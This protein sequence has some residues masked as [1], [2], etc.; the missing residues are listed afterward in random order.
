M[1][2]ATYEEILE[3]QR[4]L[5]YK[6]LTGDCISWS[7]LGAIPHQGSK[8]EYFIPRKRPESSTKNGNKNFRTGAG[9]SQGHDVLYGEDPFAEGAAI[10]SFNRKLQNEKFP[11]SRLTRKMIVSALG[12]ASDSETPLQHDRTAGFSTH[13]EV[14]SRTPRDLP[15]KINTLL[16]TLVM[17][18]NLVKQLEA[19]N[20]A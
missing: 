9:S 10:A 6:P 1:Y 15:L 11:L 2:N 8:R 19:W 20:R 18:E 3:E 12:V 13:R 5:L 14:G 17:T 16:P 7:R 4:K